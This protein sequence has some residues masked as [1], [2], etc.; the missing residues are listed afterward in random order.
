M[1]VTTAV[2]RFEV[3]V[4]QV[5]ESAWK[6]TARSAFGGSQRS[7]KEAE[8]TCVMPFDAVRKALGL[9]EREY[10][11]AQERRRKRLLHKRVAP[12]AGV[13]VPFTSP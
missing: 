11:V 6:A 1:G 3:Q 8:A 13:V 9:I 5:Q 10:V 7:V 4:R 2:L 12:R